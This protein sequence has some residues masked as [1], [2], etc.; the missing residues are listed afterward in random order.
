MFTRQGATTSDLWKMSQVS[1]QSLRDFMEKFNTAMSE[2][3]VH[4]HMALDALQNAL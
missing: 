1:G 2:V 4:G 3:N